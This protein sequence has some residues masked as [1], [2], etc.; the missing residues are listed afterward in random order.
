MEQGTIFRIKGTP[1]GNKEKLMK[2]RLDKIKL[3][4]GWLYVYFFL[5]FIILRKLT[6]EWGF[7]LVM[8]AMISF[9]VD[10]FLR[11]N[12]KDDSVERLV[13]RNWKLVLFP[14]LTWTIS[15]L[16]YI[17]IELYTANPGDFQ[18]DFSH[19]VFVLTVGMLMIVLCSV[20][21]SFLLLSKKQ[22]KFLY[23]I[24]FSVV[25]MGY[26]QG[27]FLNKNMGIL[28]G[29]SQ[30]WETKTVVI[31][32]IIW[33]VVILALVFILMKNDKV[34]T[35]VTA[36][37]IYLCMVQMVA[38]VFLI[39][40][41]NTNSNA[42][43]KAFTDKGSLEIS[44][45]NNV[46]VLL[47]DRFD[48]E[49]LENA[50]NINSEIAEELKD[51]SYY[52]NATCEFS[53]TSN[54][55]PYLLTGTSRPRNMSEQ[56]YTEYAYSESDF[57]TQIQ[58]AGYKIGLYTN[59]D[60]VPEK[61]RAVAENN[62]D[63][64]K[65]QCGFFST[66]STMMECSKYRMAPLCF[67]DYYY[68]YTSVISDLIDNKEIWNIDDD[69]PFYEKLMKKGL[70][71]SED[72][73]SKGKFYFYHMFGT[74]GPTNLSEDMRP[75]E[76]GSVSMEE[77]TQASM[78]IVLEY[79]KQLKEIGR[80]E[81]A[82]IIITADH[83]VQLDAQYYKENNVVDRTTNPVILIKESKE[84]HDK[85][86]VNEKPV[87]QSSFIPTVLEALDISYNGSDKVFDD[88]IEK[89]NSERTYESVCGDEIDIFAIKGDARIKENWE[90]IYSN[91]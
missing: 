8:F 38:V 49:F 23:S 6:A 7:V 41:G 81:D 52:P 59:E 37:S 44:Q 26:V 66:I 15:T 25:F 22:A 63:D 84:N 32:S 72:T 70:S 46:I 56:E 87:S 17:P 5:G 73:D 10:I 76:S 11:K 69:Y 29:D 60:L 90:L 30:V 9:L 45:G 83:G 28:T 50:M 35:I 68:Y 88:V 31:N 21:T 42:K 36:V 80:Y 33:L 51:F 89:D 77:Q 20:V 55:I 19:Y 82:T 12:Q 39:F 2:K 4:F 14:L 71:I 27:M 47:L 85:M 65:K 53:R 86:V 1:I 75:V 74:H 62:D 57:L 43:F 3:M 91:H 64:I 16:I 61:Y 34:T 13:L 40:T 67:K 48:I 18:F 24:L 79:L 78:N 54:A 58:N